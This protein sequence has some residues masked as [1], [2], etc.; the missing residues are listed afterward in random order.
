D[1]FARKQFNQATIAYHTAALT[2]SPDAQLFLKVVQTGLR[3][4]PFDRTLDAALRAAS[5]LPNDPD[6]QV[7]AARLMLPMRKYP[8][9]VQR[10]EKVA[11]AR[12]ADA[13]MLVLIANAKARLPSSVIAL[14]LG[15]AA[16]NTETFVGVSGKS[17]PGV[18]PLSTPGNTL[19]ADAEAENVF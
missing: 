4:G 12:P 18:T 7:R 17:R 5:L 11:I 15:F 16:R 6:V 3:A 1:L 2:G 9:I 10:M 8:D 19:S 14:S 13:G